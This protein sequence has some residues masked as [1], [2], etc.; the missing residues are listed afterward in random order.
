MKGL[1]VALYETK[2][3]INCSNG[4][5]SSRCKNVLLVGIGI[6]EILEESEEHPP[7]HIVEREVYGEKYLTAYPI[8][9]CPSNKAGY[10]FGGTFI[11]SSDSRFPA[12][13]P[14][15]LHDRTE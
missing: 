8:E 5:I 4:G 2:D 1:L 3:R 14:V 13:Y 11:Y 6:P 9:P 12:T 7:V 15:P 10:M